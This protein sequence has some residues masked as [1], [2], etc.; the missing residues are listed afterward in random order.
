[1]QHITGMLQAKETLTA[2]GY[3]IETPNMQQHEYV[4]LTKQARIRL[5]HT[6]I[7]EH[8]D[9]ISTSDAVL[10]FN[11]EKNGVAGYIG[12]S[13]LMEMAFAYTQGIEIFVLHRAPDIS[14]Q[15]EI[16]AMQPIMLS[17]DLH[18]IDTYF[19]KLPKTYVSS[20]SPI[21]LRAVSRGMRRAGMYTTVLPL[22]TASS[23]A[24]EPRSIE[25]TYQGAQNRHE[26]L[27]AIAANHT[28]EYLV[29]IESGL[30]AVHSDHNVFNSE[31]VIMEAIGV[32]QKVGITMET[33]YPH[34]MTSQVPSKYPDIGVLVQ[35]EFGSALKDPFP[36]FTNGKVNRLKLLE[37]A[38]FGVAAQL[39][40]K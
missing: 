17:G 34:T 33:E 6:L 40:E 26:K 30:H 27:R 31:V 13:T 3:E 12:G 23:V 37:E 32:Q 10:I 14:Y 4:S 29:T 1:M 7:Q 35:K 39:E 5:K 28:P 20:E 16:M 25:E 22:P 24:E 21:K 8:L 15:D 9:K 2:L 11:E 19:Q 36:F 18:A 38:V